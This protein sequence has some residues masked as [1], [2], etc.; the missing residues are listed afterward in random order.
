MA[1]G[2][3]SL[4][5]AF[6]FSVKCEAEEEEEPSHQLRKEDDEEIW[7]IEIVYFAGWERNGYGNIISS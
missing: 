2:R 7:E 5:A 3:S 1:V 4:L 6:I